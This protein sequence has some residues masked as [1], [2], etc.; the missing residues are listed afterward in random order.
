MDIILRGDVI[1]SIVG[2]YICQALGFDDGR[3]VGRGVGEIV[4]RAVGT[5]VVEHGLI[6]CLCCWLAPK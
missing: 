1:G 2:L 5:A 6:V 3:N 4:G